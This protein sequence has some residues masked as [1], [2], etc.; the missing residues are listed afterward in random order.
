MDAGGVWQGVGSRC[1]LPAAEGYGF[2][3][4]CCDFGEESCEDF[5]LPVNL[6]VPVQ[7]LISLQISIVTNSSV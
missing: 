7:M 5:T 3:G 4:A 2:C 1:P 6:V